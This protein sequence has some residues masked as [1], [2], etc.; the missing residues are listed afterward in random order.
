MDTPG[1]AY[2]LSGGWGRA[3]SPER[4]DDPLLACHR[5][6]RARPRRAEALLLA[7]YGNRRPRY[8]IRAVNLISISC[9]GIARR[10]VVR[11]VL[12]TAGFSDR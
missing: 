1:K 12:A 7:P 11:I 8:Q 6:A 2:S 4:A 5:S 10:E 3:P 9:V